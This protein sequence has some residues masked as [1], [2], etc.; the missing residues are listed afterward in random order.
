MELGDTRRAYKLFL[1]AAAAGDAD[2]QVAIAYH[3][4]TGEFS[5]LSKA[6]ALYWYQQ[7]AEQDSSSALFNL[8]LNEVEFG[9]PARALDLMMRAYSFGELDALVYIIELLPY[10]NRS[11][12][13][14][15][16]FSKKLKYALRHG[17]LSESLIARAGAILAL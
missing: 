12:E 11:A 14:M 13:D 16:F 15:A 9:E 7:A 5:W 8:G 4:E 2:A 1:Q 10:S 3:I 6:D 17:A